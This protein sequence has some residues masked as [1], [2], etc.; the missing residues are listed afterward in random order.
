MADKK[1]IILRNDPGRK[2]N[3]MRH[4]NLTIPIDT[5]LDFHEL[6]IREERIRSLKLKQS[7]LWVEILAWGLRHWPNR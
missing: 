4:I 1:K 7:D 3:R 2:R 5:A 6:H